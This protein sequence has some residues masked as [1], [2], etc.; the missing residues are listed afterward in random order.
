MKKHLSIYGAVYIIILISLFIGAFIQQE[1]VRYRLN[2]YISESQIKID[3][4]AILYG[5]TL[6]YSE[7]SH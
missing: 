2:K 3:R 7:C 4:D 5:K 1:I 6:D